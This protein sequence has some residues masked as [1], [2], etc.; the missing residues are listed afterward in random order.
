IEVDQRNPAGLERGAHAQQRRQQALAAAALRAGYGDCRQAL[1]HHGFPR[2]GMYT[3]TWTYTVYVDAL[4]A[5]VWT[6][7]CTS[8]VDVDVHSVRLR[9]TTTRTDAYSR[10]PGFRCALIVLTQYANMLAH[11]VYDV[12]A[13]C[14]ILCLRN[15][16]NFGLQIGRPADRRRGNRPRNHAI[17]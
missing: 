5:E 15:G 14:S 11:Y 17:M 13:K 9:K 16:I 12:A 1:F 3:W 8:T 2:R 6:Q 7:T 10:F 4:R